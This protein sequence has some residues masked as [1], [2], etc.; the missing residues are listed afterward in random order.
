MTEKGKEKKE[1]RAG[2]R[3]VT[4]YPEIMTVKQAA[5]YLQMNVQ[6]LYRHIRARTVPASRIGKAIRFHKS[7]LDAWIKDQAWRS[8]ADEIVRQIGHP[9]RK[10]VR[11]TLNME[12][13]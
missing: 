2:L 6:V 7:V 13:D 12:E 9:K 3:R 5:A 10:P 4:V 11:G 1:S 8:L